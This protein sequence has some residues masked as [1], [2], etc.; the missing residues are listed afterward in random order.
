[1]D[2]DLHRIPLG[3]GT[4]VVRALCHSAPV[5]R[6]DDGPAVAQAV[7]AVPRRDRAPA[8][9]VDPGPACAVG[10]PVRI[11]DDAGAVQPVL[12]LVPAGVAAGQSARSSAAQRN[13]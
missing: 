5:A 4:G 2:L 13:G 10:D 8:E 12:D 7:A 11:A 9:R 1:M 3:A 6:T